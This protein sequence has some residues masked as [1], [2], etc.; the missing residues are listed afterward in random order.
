MLFHKQTVVLVSIKKNFFRNIFKFLFI[1]EQYDGK[2]YTDEQ[3]QQH[4]E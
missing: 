3:I 2:T 1:V 4:F